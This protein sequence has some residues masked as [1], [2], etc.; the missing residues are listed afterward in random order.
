[1]KIFLKKISLAIA[2]VFSQTILFSQVNPSDRLLLSSSRHALTKLYDQELGGNTRLYNG[3]E[4]IDPFEREK[5][6]GFPY[7]ITD[8]WQDGSI[9]YDGQLYQNIPMMFDTYQN[10]VIIDHPKSHTKIELIAEKIGYFIINDK[11]FV[12]L[13][14]PTEGFYEQ[15]YTGEI[16]I[17][18][19][20]YTTIQEKVG[21]EYMITEF[22]KKRKLYILKNNIYFPITSKKSALNVLK[23]HKNEL[24]KF[25]NQENISFKRDKELALA[26]MGKYF[27]HLNAGR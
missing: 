26:R 1:V 2:V 6:E 11:F 5:T 7:F 12:R 21:S 22:R 9:L 10:R 16:K 17:Y 8:D 24:N 13:Q 20:H 27:D 19:R 25:L 15:L 18:A 23:D 3:I 4:F 14:N